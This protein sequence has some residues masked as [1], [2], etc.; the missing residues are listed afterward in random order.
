MEGRTD[1][2]KET[3]LVI[4]EDSAIQSASFP[5]AASLQR[6]LLQAVRDNVPEWPRVVSLDRLLADLTITRAETQTESI[7]LKDGPPKII[8]GKTLAV[9][10]LIDGAPM[11]RMV[12]GTRYARTLN[13]PALMLYDSAGGTFYLDGGQWWMTAINLNGPWTTA[14][15]PPDE[16]AG[17]KQILTKE[18]EPQASVQPAPSATLN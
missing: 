9:L 13:T 16:L 4:F 1:V 10:I 15:N 11:Y 6:E 18:E 17:I 7:P 12:E 8:F 14:A 5:S 2:D 3:R